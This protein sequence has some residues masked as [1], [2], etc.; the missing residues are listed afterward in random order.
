MLSATNTTPYSATLGGYWEDLYPAVSAGGMRGVRGGL[1]LRDCL[2]IRFIS[3]YTTEHRGTTSRTTIVLALALRSRE[4][5]PWTGRTW[6]RTC[7]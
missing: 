3:I 7:R 2:L 5:P 4:G 6:M 1:I